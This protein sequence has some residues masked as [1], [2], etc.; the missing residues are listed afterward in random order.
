MTG[1]RMRSVL[2]TAGT[3]E[4]ALT[5][6]WGWIAVDCIKIEAAEAIPQSAY[7]VDDTLTDPDANIDARVLFSYLCDR[8]GEQVLAGQFADRGLDSDEF[9][10]IKEYTLIVAIVSR[11]PVDF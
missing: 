4:I 9:R 6:S 1:A 10:A 11:T 5:K 3:H 2:L 8:Y 7:E